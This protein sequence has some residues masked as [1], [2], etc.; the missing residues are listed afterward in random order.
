MRGKALAVAV[1][2]VVASSVSQ[3]QAA[4]ISWSDA[5]G[6]IS[7]NGLLKPGAVRSRAMRRGGEV[8]SINLCRGGSGYVY[9]LTVL[10][11]KKRVRDI[12]V[13]ARS[14]KSLRGKSSSRKRL[15]DR[16]INRVKRNLRRYGINY[17]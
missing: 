2:V 13:D 11:R 7:K 14:G 17:Y 16:I 15:K 9:R 8:I 3:A 4:C 10:G 6:V 5:R 12:V 1:F